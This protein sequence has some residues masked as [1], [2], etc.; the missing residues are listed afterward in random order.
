MREIRIS[1][2]GLVGALGAIIYFLI[3][4]AT[5]GAGATMA[6]MLGSIAFR[7]A[8]A[9]WLPV[10]GYVISG[11]AGLWAV[12]AGLSWLY[13]TNPTIKIGGKPKVELPKATVHKGNQ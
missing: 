8:D 3:I 4:V 13:E 6:Y 1:Y 7:E 12:V 9:S 11:I 10:I 2:R 5:V